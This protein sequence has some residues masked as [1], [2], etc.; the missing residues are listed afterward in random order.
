MPEGVEVRP[1]ELRRGAGQ[2]RDAAGR[3]G[4]AVGQASHGADATGNAAGDGPLAEAASTLAAR[5]DAL[6][7]A[8]TG[9][10]IGCADA[11]DA[12]STQYLALDQGGAARLD[13]APPIVLPGIEPPR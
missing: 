9:N 12:A 2:L 8:A 4:A 5:L 3:L 11:L 1:E 10:V 13:G 6:A 7:H